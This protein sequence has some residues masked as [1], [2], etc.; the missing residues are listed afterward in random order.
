MPDKLGKRK[1][2]EGPLL[3]ALCESLLLK[4]FTFLSTREVVAGTSVC[5]VMRDSLPAAIMTLELGRHHR[6]APSF[7]LRRFT[8]LARLVLRR[9]DRVTLDH[10]FADLA[11][12]AC[13][14]LLELS[15]VGVPLDRSVLGAAEA[16]ARAV[17]GCPRLRLLDCVE[18]RGLI[19]GPDMTTLAEA[20]VRC[21]Q[22]EALDLSGN[23]MG[24]QGLQTLSLALAKGSCRRL[25]VSGHITSSQHLGRGSV[26]LTIF[27]WT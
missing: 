16:F 18:C 12:G 17:Q 14:A 24:P 3:E 4:V 25:R 27:V 10:V 1:E 8:R 21:P 11:A 7:T 19:T 9:P 2:R 22:L 13:P 26:V 5:R 23:Y 20:L 15:V 6:V